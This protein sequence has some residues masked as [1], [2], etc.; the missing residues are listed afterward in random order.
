MPTV[1]FLAI[2]SCDGLYDRFDH[3]VLK[4]LSFLVY[5]ES[6]NNYRFYKLLLKELADL[7]FLTIKEK[8]LYFFLR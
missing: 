8:E 4:Y 7:S 5:K 1:F 6:L 3:Q 2:E